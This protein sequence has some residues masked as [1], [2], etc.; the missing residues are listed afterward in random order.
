MELP[1]NDARI[2]VVLG[3]TFPWLGR[4][5]RFEHQDDAQG[6]VAVPD[7][8]P[9]AVSVKTDPRGRRYPLPPDYALATFAGKGLLPTSI[10][11]STHLGLA[12]T[13]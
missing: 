13:A 3:Q 8:Q 5:C 1:S 4:F 12:L 9:I 2:S 6:S 11:E 10:G 7:P